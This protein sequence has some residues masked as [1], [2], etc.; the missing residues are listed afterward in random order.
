MTKTNAAQTQFKNQG[1]SQ[2]NKSQSC[3]TEENVTRQ[4]TGMAKM[5]ALK[6]IRNRNR[7]KKVNNYIQTHADKNCY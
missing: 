2:K 7:P 6:E 3:D 1:T 4:I 5:K